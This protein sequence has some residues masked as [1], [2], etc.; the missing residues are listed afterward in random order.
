MRL[1]LDYRTAPIE[2]TTRQK[3]MAVFPVEVLLDEEA[4][5]LE[6]LWQAISFDRGASIDCHH[7]KVDS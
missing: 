5:S 6:T 4:T 3:L 2:G 1:Q 7:C